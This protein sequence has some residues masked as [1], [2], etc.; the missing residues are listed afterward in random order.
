M[1]PGEAIAYESLSRP[2]L[3]VSDTSKLMVR[4][5]IDETD[6]GKIK[7]GQEASI[8]ADAFPGRS[9]TARVVRISGGMGKKEILTDNPMDKVDTESWRLSWNW[10]RTPR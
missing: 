7:L 10:N 6:I 3:S 5:E 9:F 2:I 4:A 8:T 1:N